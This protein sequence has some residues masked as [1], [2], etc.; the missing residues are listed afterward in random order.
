MNPLTFHRFNAPVA[1]DSLSLVQD[2]FVSANFNDITQS[3]YSLASTFN[4][5]TGTDSETGYV[6]PGRSASFPNGG[7]GD[8]L[9]IMSGISSYNDDVTI[10]SANYTSYVSHTIASEAGP[11]G[12]NENILTM[13]LLDAGAIA[14]GVNSAFGAQTWFGFLRITGGTSPLPADIE[15]LYISYY[16]KRGSYLNTMAAGED[17]FLEIKTGGYDGAYGGDMRLAAAIVKPSSGSMYWRIKCDHSANGT[18]TTTPYGTAWPGTSTDP[19]FFYFKAENNSIT[20]PV[21]DWCRVELYI[22][23]SR[24]GG[25]L[26]LAIDDQVAIVYRGNTIGDYDNPIGRIYPHGVY[27]QNGIG[28]SKVA[29]IRM[30]DYPLPESV[31]YNEILNRLF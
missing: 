4:V 26:L 7:S 14:H 23:R 30:S 10:T 17:I 3:N 21:N 6:W 27:T 20:V 11:D 28:T 18:M 29:R 1:R 15:N 25:C 2:S 8:L 31:L 12:T 24:S 9:T 16:M 22:R 19:G 13:T 5:F